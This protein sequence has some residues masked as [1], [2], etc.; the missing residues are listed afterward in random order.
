MQNFVYRYRSPERAVEVGRRLYKRF[1]SSVM[2]E[3]NAVVDSDG[4]VVLEARF[5][6]PLQQPDR[7]RVQEIML[8]GEE[9]G[10]ALYDVI[11]RSLPGKMVFLGDA[12]MGL[13]MMF[14]E[15]DRPGGRL[16]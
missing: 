16:R 13:Q 1:S 10:E 15:E 9:V 7:E 12:L 14:P 11:M 6:N 2:T 8:P 3:L 4:S 5:G